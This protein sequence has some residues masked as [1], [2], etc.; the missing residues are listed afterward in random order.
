MNVDVYAPPPLNHVLD[1]PPNPYSYNRLL[2]TRVKALGSFTTRCCTKALQEEAQ[3]ERFLAEDQAE[4]DNDEPIEIPPSFLVTHVAVVQAITKLYDAWLRYYVV[5]TAQMRE[6]LDLK[7]ADGHA[8]KTTL[9]A[10]VFYEL[11]RLH[12]LL[13]QPQ[14]LLERENVVRIPRDR[15]VA[16]DYDVAFALIH[17]KADLWVS[18]ATASS[19]TAPSPTKAAEVRIYNADAT[20]D[21]TEPVHVVAA[22]ELR[23]KLQALWTT[24]IMQ[25]TGSQ[26]RVLAAFLTQHINEVNEATM[27]EFRRVFRVL[28]LR[29]AMLSMQ[30]WHRSLWSASLDEPEMRVLLP[31]PEEDK[32]AANRPW[33]VYCSFYLGELVRRF[34]HYDIL[35]PRTLDVPAAAVSPAAVEHFKQWITKSVVGTFAEE[36]FEEIHQRVV[37]EQDGAYDFPGDGSWFRYAHPTSVATLGA[38]ITALRPHL[39]ERFFS[40]EQVDRNVILASV[41]RSHLARL[42][43]LHALDAYIKITHARVEYLNGV[44]IDNGGIEQSAYTLKT[45]VAPLLLQVFGRYW[46]YWKGRVHISDDIWT[47]LTLWWWLLRE[48]HESKLYGIDLSAFVEEALLPRA[49][50]AP[51]VPDPDAADA[52]GF[53]L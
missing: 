6:I 35:G 22:R 46:V 31:P 19:V 1:G 18:I 4:G 53:E 43:V 17:T 29:C 52:R 49:A 2:M 21:T 23:R 27:E 26:V 33:A 13:A 24:P 38:T 30:G 42:F 44:V 41:H 10:H 25:Y 5:S 32:A 39:Y 34:Y 8:Y 47:T 12:W 11:T 3:V 20:K 28:W 45:G 15:W 48:H 37:V 7:M 36:A 14:L 9:G 50:G 16:S 40:E 51:L